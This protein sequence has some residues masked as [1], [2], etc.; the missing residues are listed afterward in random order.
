MPELPEV[1][2]VCRGLSNMIAGKILARVVMR[3]TNLRRPIPADLSTRVA[4]MRLVTVTRRAK[5][6]L[7]NF[8]GGGLESHSAA[9]KSPDA[10]T[11]LIHL[12][13]SGRILVT[14]PTPLSDSQNPQTETAYA[15]HDHVEFIF[16]DATRMIFNDPRRFGLIDWAATADLSA[17]PLLAGLGPEPLSDQFS[18]AYLRNVLA[19]KKTT[20][21]SALLDQYGVVGLG[22][23]YVCE[24]L[25]HARISPLRLAHEV[26]ADE[27]KPLHAAI[28]KVLQSAIAAGGSSW[29][30]YAK[31]DGDLG[32]FQTMT[33]VYGREGEK[34]LGGKNPGK[35]YMGKK[36]QDKIVRQMQSGRSSFF[37]PS[38]QK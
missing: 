34:C 29:R 22:N 21:K 18:Q 4:G 9:K 10:V 33:K 1:E 38:C 30:D 16:A 17:H 12:G 37:C 35:N 31:P 19:G 25:F 32:Y 13:M 15:K 7:L 28:Q 2:T 20:I 23:I 8:V 5:Y 11:V 26:K 36:C 3:R 14:K 6:I 27:I 24:A